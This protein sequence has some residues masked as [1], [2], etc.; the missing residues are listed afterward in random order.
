VTSS[1][2]FEPGAYAAGFIPLCVPEIRGNE[3]KYVQ[4]CLRT[5]WVSSV[6][7]YVDDFERLFAQACERRYAVATVN[8]TAA[9]HTALVALD[10]R[11]DEEVLVSTLTFI[12]PANAIRYA[13]AHPVFIDAEE[14]SWQMSVVALERFLTN[15]CRYDGKVLRNRESNRIV[16]AII[17]V[18]ILG[19]PCNMPE[20]AKLARAYGLHI[21]EDATESLG[22]RLHTK[23]VGNHADVVCFSFNGNKLITTGGGGMI[24][25]DDEA[26]AKRAKYLTTQAKDDPIEYIH[27]S[28]GFNYRL[29]NIQAAMGVAQLEQLEQFISLKRRHAAFYRDAL[30]N[31]DGITP[32]PTTADGFDTFW[33]YTIL[34]DEHRFGMSSRDLLHFLQERRIQTRPLWQPL[35]R[36]PAHLGSTA[37]GGDV[38]EMLQSKALSLPSSVGL[39]LDE[40]RTVVDAI[41]AAGAR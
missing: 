10:V 16:R 7:S 27:G 19:S 11:P 23:H 28:V 25:T 5:G 31:V 20:I 22:A 36:S 15:S 1:A 35:H 21:I 14:D 30:A 4:D 29:T 13:G 34:V 6:G 12:A 24:A 40:A 3:D 41:R 2:V 8:G 32:M 18:D 38:A 9:I 17:P 26:L 37:V 39:S 33:L